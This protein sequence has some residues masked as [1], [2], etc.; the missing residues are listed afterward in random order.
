MIRPLGYDSHSNSS[1]FICG[2]CHSAKSQYTC[3]NCST[4]YCSADCYNSLKHSSCSE[5][6]Y[7]GVIEEHLKGGKKHEPTSE[8]LNDRKKLV[9]LLHKYSTD[10]VSKVEHRSID[11]SNNCDTWKYQ[12]PKRIE[13]SLQSLQGKFSTEDLH[14]LQHIDNS[15]S[16]YEN[17][18]RPLTQD[19]SQEFEIVVNDSSTDKLL[20]MLSPEQRK[21]FENLIKN[22]SY[23]VED[24]T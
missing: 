17:E 4:L 2:I 24:D 19:E 9:T 5:K 21:E 22:S 6:F 8:E 15:D 23:V 12:A 7:Q 18:D 16:E 20:S 11:E 3:P 1:D 13:E 10:D 14:K